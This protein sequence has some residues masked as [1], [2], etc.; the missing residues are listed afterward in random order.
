ML[1][2]GR[3]A[4]VAG[5]LAELETRK[6]IAVAGEDYDAAKAIKAEIDRVRAAAGAPSGGQPESSP[7]LQRCEA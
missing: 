6:A 2:A 1:L 5:R 7:W 3:L 4:S